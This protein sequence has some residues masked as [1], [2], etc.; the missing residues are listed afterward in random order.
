MKIIS[1]FKDY[2][3]YKVSEYGLDEKLVFDRR[4]P[5]LIA[6]NGLFVDKNFFKEASD[7]DALHLVLY[8]GNEL[9]HLFATKSHIYTHFDVKNIDEFKKYQDHFG[10]QVELQLT[11]GNVITITSYLYTQNNYTL[12][13]QLGQNRAKNIY[14]VKDIDTHGGKVLQ[15]E[16]FAQKPLLLIQR[17]GYNSAIMIDANPF[18]AHTGIYID[19]DFVWQNI[20]QFLSDLKSQAEKSPEVPNDQKITNKGFDKKTSF[21]PKMKKK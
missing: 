4:D 8:V 9:V 16:D 19:P 17:H 1:Q 21:R 12:Y 18:L 5:V 6:K 14:G 13:E 20:V 11:D 15:W 3:D 10:G 2:Y 7:T